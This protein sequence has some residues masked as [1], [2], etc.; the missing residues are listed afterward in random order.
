VAGALGRCCG[1]IDDGCDLAHAGASDPPGALDGNIEALGAFIRAH[2]V[3]GLER[4]D[5]VRREAHESDRRA[6]LASLTPAGREVAA[7]ATQAL[8]EA[9][10]CTAPL[11][12]AELERLTVTLRRIRL[13][14]GDFQPD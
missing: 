7:A 2:I 4:M 6:T 3:D 13:D 10:F 1:A 5:L 11:S 12:A 8:N 14:A 9:R